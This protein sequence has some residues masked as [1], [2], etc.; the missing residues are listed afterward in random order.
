MEITRHHTGA[1]LS[2]VVVYNHTAYLCG[3]V[4]HDLEADITAQTQSAL[5]RIDAHLAEAGT[6]KSKLLACT[7]YLKNPGDVTA[8]N[9]VWNDWLKDCQTPTRTCVVTGFANPNILVEIT[10]IA[11]V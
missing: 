2:R 8:M 4:G 6:D 5:A 1:K 3:Q 9:A 7:V 11:A 10:P